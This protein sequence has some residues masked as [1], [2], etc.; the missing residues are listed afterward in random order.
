VEVCAAQERREAGAANRTAK[1]AVA[2]AEAQQNT[3]GVQVA[4]CR[5]VAAARPP[6]RRY[7]VFRPKVVKD[8]PIQKRMGER[9]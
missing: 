2:G 1:A 7:S 9:W 5:E 3:A 6:I 4:R 8:N